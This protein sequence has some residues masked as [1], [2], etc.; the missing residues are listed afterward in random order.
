MLS[1]GI[2]RSVLG[3]GNKLCYDESMLTGVTLDEVLFFSLIQWKTLILLSFFERR[4]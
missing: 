4:K 1:Y 2:V 3:F